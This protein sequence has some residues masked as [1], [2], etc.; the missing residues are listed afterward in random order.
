M[1]I[2]GYYCH[3]T[4][5][6]F[7]QC[8][9]ATS[10]SS[11]SSTTKCNNSICEDHINSCGMTYGGCYLAGTCGGPVPSF[12][13]PPCVSPTPTSTCITGPTIVTMIT[14]TCTYT[15]CEDHINS[16]GMTYGGCFLDPLCGGTRPT[17][18]TPPCP[19]TMPPSGCPF[20]EC[21]YV[22]NPCGPSIRTCFLAGA[23]GGTTPGPRTSTCAPSQS[24][25]TWVY[26]TSNPVPS[27]TT[28]L[29]IRTPIRTGV[30]TPI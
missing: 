21:G 20:T 19:V 11:S 30:P 14:S 4:N 10:T 12:T 16:C 29:T 15:R 23:C 22:S 28:I 27:S 1:C 24:T 2:S 18:T 13:A 17:F 26:T 25:S 8:I 3:N 6:Y 5:A 9:P 7:S